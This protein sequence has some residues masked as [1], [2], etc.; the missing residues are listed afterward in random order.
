MNNASII[1]N[2]ITIF[3]IF[4]LSLKIDKHANPVRVIRMI[5]RIFL[6]R[7][8]KSEIHIQ[9]FQLSLVVQPK[10]Q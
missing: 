2:G 5:F 1:V 7:G 8:S 10:N 4:Y 3:Q 9:E 6:T